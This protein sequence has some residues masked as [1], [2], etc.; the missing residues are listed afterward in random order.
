MSSEIEPLY[1]SCFAEPPWNE[2]EEKLAQSSDRLADAAGRPG[3]T[4]LAARDPEGTL[5][6][7][8]YGWPT[9]PLAGREIYDKLVARLGTEQA[10]ALTRGAFEFVE[11]MVSPDARGQGLGGRLLA[12]ADPWP[13]AWL[14]TLADSPAE[15]LY[16]RHGW[17]EHCRLLDDAW[18][19]YTRE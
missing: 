15:R 19:I 5:I 17:Q 1:R 16:K 13:R 3:F 18:V 14:A 11:L 9:P 7:L 12:L 2:P 6:G 8:A 4:A 10:H